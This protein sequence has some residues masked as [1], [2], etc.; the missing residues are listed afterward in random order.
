MHDLCIHFAHN[1]SVVF[2]VTPVPFF[3]IEGDDFGIF[4][5]LRDAAFTPSCSGCR[6]VDLQQLMRSGGMPSVLGLVGCVSPP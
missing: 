1:A 3:L 5:V 4:N 2:S 6:R